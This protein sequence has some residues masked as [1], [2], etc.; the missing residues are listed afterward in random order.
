MTK[1]ME[2][3]RDSAF[4]DCSNAAKAIIQGDYQVAVIFADRALRLAKYL[5]DQEE[6]AKKF[7]E[8]M[9]SGRLE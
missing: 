1:E 5:L 9:T 2:D 4:S 7:A 3:A 8:E 6:K